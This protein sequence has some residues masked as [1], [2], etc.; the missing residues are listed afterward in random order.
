MKIDAA[1]STSESG[2]SQQ[3]GTTELSHSQYQSEGVALPS[4][5]VRFSVDSES[6][7]RLQAGLD[8]VADL[9]GDRVAALRQLI[10]DG[11]YHVSNQAIAQAMS[12]S[13]VEGGS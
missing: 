12:S 8:E 7:R 6:V 1:V 13:L 5:E 4:D 10:G 3:V 11:N 2:R 9:R